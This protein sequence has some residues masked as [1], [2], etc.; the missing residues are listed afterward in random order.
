MRLSTLFVSLVLL[1]SCAE[2]TPAP[3]IAPGTFVYS[4]LTGAYGQV[5]SAN[6]R[7]GEAQCRCY[8]VRWGNNQRIPIG[9]SP[10]SLCYKRFELSL[11]P[12]DVPA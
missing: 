12:V 7:E 1:G 3:D 6:C 10:P 9:S 5:V 11:E 8:Y 4:V 2:P